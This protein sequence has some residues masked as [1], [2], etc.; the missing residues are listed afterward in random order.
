MRFRVV[1]EKWILF[2]ACKTGIRD[3]SSNAF[4]WYFHSPH[5]THEPP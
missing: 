5:F 2:V 3:L 4:S 1:S